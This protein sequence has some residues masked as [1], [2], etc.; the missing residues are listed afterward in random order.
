M[1]IVSDITINTVGVVLFIPVVTIGIAGILVISVVSK[2]GAVV[3]LGGKCISGGF[4]D[5][6]GVIVSA[7]I[8]K[9]NQ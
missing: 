7:H 8:P 4:S 3:Y 9:S 1:L 5:S 2:V 6:N